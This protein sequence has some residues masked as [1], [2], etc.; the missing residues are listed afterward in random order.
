MVLAALI[1]LLSSALFCFY[2]Q[3]TVQRIVRR[4]FDREYFLTIVAANRLE[5]LEVRRAIEETHAPIHSLQ[6]QTSLRC[7]FRA[8]TC[9]LKYAAN[10]SQSYTHEE[11]LLMLYFR[12]AFLSLIA[13]HALRL[14]EKPAI[15]KLTAILLHFANVV[16]KRV[17]A[18]RFADLAPFDH[19]LS[20]KSL[21]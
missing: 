17:N 19:L 3:I 1:L 4:Q 12:V 14:S 13:R 7:D 9:L 8:L 5:F 20:C 2:L 15:L 6:A 16:G 11:R 10:L 21:S 18:L